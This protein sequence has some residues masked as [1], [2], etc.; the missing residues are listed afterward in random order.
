[1]PLLVLA[2][3][4]KGMRFDIDD[5]ADGEIECLNDHVVIV[6][7]G[8]CEFI[9]RLFESDERRFPRE[10][11]WHRCLRFSC[12]FLAKRFFAFNIHKR[13]NRAVVAHGSNEK[14]ISHGRVSWQTDWTYFRVGPLAS[15]SR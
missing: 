5:F 15:S 12:G 11:I 1:M 2:A 6:R 4:N 7:G 10:K 14:E 9:D 13:V 3:K 8:A